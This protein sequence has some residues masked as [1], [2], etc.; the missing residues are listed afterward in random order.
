M[1]SSILRIGVAA[2]VAVVAAGCAPADPSK[3][4]QPKPDPTVKQIAAAPPDVTPSPKAST[5]SAE[6]GPFIV[7]DQDLRARRNADGQVKV[8]G[9][10]IV[11]ANAFMSTVAISARNDGYHPQCT[12]VLIKPDVV[13]TAAHCVCGVVA[14]PA[15]AASGFAYFGPRPTAVNSGAFYPVTAFESAIACSGKDPRYSLRENRDLAVLRLKNPN[16]HVPVANYR[17]A[18]ALVDGAKGFRV[19]GFGATDQDGEIVD[20]FKREAGL[21][22]VSN[23]CR[24]HKDDKPGGPTDGD[25]YGC[26]PGEEIVAGQR[27]SPDSCNGD[28]GG[29]LF[30][31]PEGDGQATPSTRFIL[32]G[33]VSRPVNKSPRACGYGG[34]YERLTPGAVAWIDGAIK[35]LKK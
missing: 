14:T 4:G 5:P 29:P 6:E 16:I 9:G 11:A 3:P 13:L 32:A 30:V 26:W 15:G 33:I 22:A 12:G 17:P 24:S 7:V 31:S 21:A 18:G 28:S 34:L 25:Y 10:T 35:R 23:D 1:S 19:V 20:Y 27:Q 8:Y 2:A